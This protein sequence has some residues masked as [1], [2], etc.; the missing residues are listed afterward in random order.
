MDKENHFRIFESGPHNYLLPLVTRL[1]SLH[2]GVSGLETG[3][4]KDVSRVLEISTLDSDTKT[5]QFKLLDKVVRIFAL[6]T[7][8]AVL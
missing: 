7:S 2:L 6:G 5:L 8:R 1:G 3:L 4:S